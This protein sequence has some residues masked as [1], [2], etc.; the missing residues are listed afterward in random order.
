MSVSD[1]TWRA[2]A[3]DRDRLVKQAIQAHHREHG[4]Y[5]P[6]FG[7]VVGYTAV[8]MA[9]YGIDFGLPY[10]LNGDRA[11]PMQPVK[12]LGEAG[13]GTKRGDTRLTGLFR[14]TPI[15]ILT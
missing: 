15:V 4:S 14:D 12:R 11:G 2:C 8:V 1:E 7:A 9:G 3:G 6:A 10:D 5:V 13:L